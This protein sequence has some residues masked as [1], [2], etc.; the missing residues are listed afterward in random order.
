ME[1]KERVSSMHIKSDISFLDTYFGWLKARFGVAEGIDVSV[2]ALHS[3]LL[4][5]AVR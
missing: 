4:V 3:S 1:A 5:L 2:A